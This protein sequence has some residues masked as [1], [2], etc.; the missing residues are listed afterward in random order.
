MQEIIYIGVDVA[1][2]KIDLFCKNKSIVIKNKIKGI[3]STFKKLMK[4]NETYFVVC[5]TTGGHEQI[6]FKILRDLNIF[7][8]IE[9]PN[10][11]RT[12]A[13]SLGKLAITDKIDSKILF[14]Y[15]LPMNP[16]ETFLLKMKSENNLIDLLKIGYELLK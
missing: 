15:G 11:L 16:E 7:V 5:E 4:L 9:R 6:L 8:K 13:K 12:I 14:K 2:E 3:K 10:K 1:K